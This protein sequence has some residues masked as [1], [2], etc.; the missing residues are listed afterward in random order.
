MKARTA[1]LMM[2]W[3]DEVWES[4][5]FLEDEPF[6]AREL[7]KT[8]AVWRCKIFSDLFSSDNAYMTV[9]GPNLIPYFSSSPVL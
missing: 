4:F 5:C 8:V 9:S 1:S 2:T 3:L 6:G 7:E